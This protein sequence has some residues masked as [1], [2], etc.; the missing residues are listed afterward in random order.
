MTR[1]RLFCYNTQKRLRIHLQ[2]AV[3][4]ERLI[5]GLSVVTDD[6]EMRM[7]LVTIMAIAGLE[8]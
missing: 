5:G 1:G 4:D 7:A 8:L 3:Q 2:V 6:D